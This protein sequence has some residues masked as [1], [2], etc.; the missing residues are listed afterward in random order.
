MSGKEYVVQVTL[1]TT[2]SFPGRR[3]PSRPGFYQWHDNQRH[4]EGILRKGSRI[5]L[6]YWDGK[7]WL[8]T[9]S[10]G[11]LVTEPGKRDKHGKIGEPEFVEIRKDREGYWLGLVEMP[12]FRPMDGDLTISEEHRSYLHADFPCEVS[13]EGYEE[14]E[15]SLLDRYGALLNVLMMKEVEAVTNQEKAFV[16]MCSGNCHPKGK[17]DHV[18]KKYRLDVL[19]KI[20]MAMERKAS[21]NGAF[22]FDIYRKR[23][24]ELATHGHPDA[25]KWVKSNHGWPKGYPTN[26]TPIKLMDADPV[27][28]PTIY[29]RRLNGSYGSSRRR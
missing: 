28:T 22:D 25:I 29:T 20:A 24:V 1:K 17:V 4:S 11:I 13:I 5:K 21:N 3:R 23:V 7:R 9:T 12:E 14:F 2:R 16:E 15:R 10:G 18:W 6:D 8:A 19:Y 27:V 26:P